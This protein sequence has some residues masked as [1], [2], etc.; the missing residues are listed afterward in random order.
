MPRCTAQSLLPK[1]LLSVLTC[2]RPC[3]IVEL[4]VHVDRVFDDDACTCGYHLAQHVY[5]YA[6]CVSCYSSSYICILPS[7]AFVVYFSMANVDAPCEVDG[8]VG[9]YH[10]SSTTLCTRLE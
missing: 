5:T 2:D 8:S 6:A 9:Y 10:H 7:H 4:L 3:S 1:P